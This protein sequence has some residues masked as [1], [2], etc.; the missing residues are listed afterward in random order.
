MGREI[1]KPET[2]NGRSSV[3][4]VLVPLAAL[5]ASACGSDSSGPDPITLSF[6]VQ[7]TTVEAGQP[8]Q[9]DVTVTTS[10]S[11]PQTVTISIADDRCGATLSGQTSRQASDGV[12]V[13]QGLAIDIPADDYQLEARVLDRTSR[14]AQFDAV[15]SDLAGPLDQQPT[16][17]LKDRP[18]GD[19]S[20]LTWVQVDNVMWTADDNRN[21]L[22]GLDLQSGVCLN[23][24][25]AEDLISAFPDASNC[26]DGDGDPATS[27]SY[28]NE[29][30][31]VA[32]DDRY[33][34]L[35]V[36]NTVN[37]PSSP[38]ILDRPAVFRLRRGACRA[39]IE[40]DSWNRLPPDYT[41]RAAVAIDGRQYISNGTDLHRYDY[42]LNSVTA[43]PVLQTSGSTIT[44]LS[45]WNGTLFVL[46][47][48]RQ[49]AEV[50][51]NTLEP[52][53][54][55]DLSPV[56]IRSAN[57][58]EVVR[59]TIYVLEGEPRNPIYVLTVESDRS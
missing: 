14:S 49:L 36:F 2:C 7:P 47:R 4:A 38:V 52:E 19:A 58:V 15:P 55:Y 35:Y 6:S 45:Y 59:D 57:G 18:V 27:C 32:Y 11:T 37:D 31:V 50:D 24:V 42:D 51:W 10:S 29:L 5:A 1:L 54:S 17:C 39:C 9:P 33:G 48:S 34:F 44:G 16:L 56:G 13:F 46:A 30:E 28:T 3:T 43:D 22:C 8:I 23:E 40:Y 25:T 20:S 53:A 41:Y 12:A 21:K 26:D